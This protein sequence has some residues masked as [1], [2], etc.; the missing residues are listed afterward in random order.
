MSLLLSKEKT[1]FT[2]LD[3]ETGDTLEQTFDT[4]KEALQFFADCEREKADDELETEDALQYASLD[5]EAILA[6]ENYTVIAK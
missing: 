2:R 4:R 3:L 1:M 5:N 6:L